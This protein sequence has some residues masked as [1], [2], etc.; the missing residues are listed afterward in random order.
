MTDE[1]ASEYNDARKVFVE[2]IKQTMISKKKITDD[3]LRKTCGLYIATED[4]CDGNYIDSFEACI[5]AAIKAASN[6]KATELSI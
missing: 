4:K 3:I 1:L 6:T 5:K 2:I